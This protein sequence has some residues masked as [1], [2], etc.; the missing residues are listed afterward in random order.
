MSSVNARKEK[1]PLS[2][3]RHIGQLVPCMWA[4]AVVK[5]S[6]RGI[7]RGGGRLPESYN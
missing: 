6:T 5:M 3:T 2:A 4:I 1:C 7:R